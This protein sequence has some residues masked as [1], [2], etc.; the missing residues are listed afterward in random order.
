[1]PEKETSKPGL[2]HIIVAW[3]LVGTPEDSTERKQLEPLVAEIA[4]ALAQRR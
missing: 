2:E 1:M 4:E 3:M